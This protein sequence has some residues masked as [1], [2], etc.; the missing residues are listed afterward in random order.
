[1]RFARVPRCTLP[2]R[3]SSTVGFHGRSRLIRLP[4]R[5]RFRPVLAAFVPIRGCAW[6]GIAPSACRPAGRHRVGSSSY[7]SRSKVVCRRHARVEHAHDLDRV[8]R[9]ANR[10]KVD[11]VALLRTALEPFGEV[12]P[13]FPERR[14]VAEP[15]ET[16][17]QVVHVAV[18]RINAPLRD[19]I[20]PDLD[21]DL[22]KVHLRAGGKPV[23]HSLPSRSRPA[24]LIRSAS[25]GKASGA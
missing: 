2:L 13:G 15:C 16:D 24:A 21:P 5:C 9:S 22:G 25:L 3:C 19:A 12:R 6:P 11:D 7:P 18:R 14:V 20:E 17:H 1:M 10:A 4:R 8:G 23:D